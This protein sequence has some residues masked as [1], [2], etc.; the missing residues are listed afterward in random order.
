MTHNI[1]SGRVTRR[2]NSER[3][4]PNWLKTIYAT[5]LAIVALVVVTSLFGTP[6]GDTLKPC[7]HEDSVNCYWDADTMGNGKGRDVVNR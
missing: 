5:L 4:T 1:I 6:A 2:A 7:K 3:H